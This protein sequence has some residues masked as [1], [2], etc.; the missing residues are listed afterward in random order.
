MPSD[1]LISLEHFC[2]PVKLSPEQIAFE[3]LLTKIKFNAELEALGSALGFD[4][5]STS[6]GIRYDSRQN[7]NH[8][9]L[10]WC[11]RTPVQT[12]S[13]LPKGW[14]G[15]DCNRTYSPDG[16]VP[17]EVQFLPQDTL[18]LDAMIGACALGFGGVTIGLVVL[19][20]G[21]EDPK[22]WVMTAGH[23]FQHSP[24]I[25]GRVDPH[26]KDNL[27]AL[28]LI[29]E[30]C[31]IC[32]K[33]NCRICPV[34]KGQGHRLE[35]E[36]NEIFNFY[37]PKLDAHYIKDQ[38]D[39]GVFPLV[40]AKLT[41]LQVSTCQE[42]IRD[43]VCDS[44]A[45]A[46]DKEILEHAQSQFAQLKAVGFPLRLDELEALK[47]EDKSGKPFYIFMKG[48]MTGWTF[49]CLSDLDT[50][51]L[52]FREPFKAVSKPPISDKGDSGALL[53]VLDRSLVARPI[54]LHSGKWRLGQTGVQYGVGLC[55]AG[56]A[57]RTLG[58]PQ[59]EPPNSFWLDQN[60][61]YT[62]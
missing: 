47:A 38:N 37:N 1:K 13:P 46:H 52:V 7:A 12:S 42:V 9:V 18:E 19:V 36:P 11:K 45:S 24:L 8:V 23:G 20:G 43:F 53:F 21:S 3:A 56:R 22:P 35:V 49:G 61:C 62:L 51:G 26:H 34:W 16:Q 28:C 50:R 14:T 39:I 57:M 29:E 41:A 17:I 31:D 48:M 5:F 55:R 10:V 15:T 59:F 25:D 30:E 32:Y 33:S 40:N 2:D 44:G 6:V 58:G 27:V 60:S 4:Q 54:A